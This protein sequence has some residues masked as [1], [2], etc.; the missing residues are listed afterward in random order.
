MENSQLCTDINIYTQDDIDANAKIIEL[1]IDKSIE[2]VK[3]MPLDELRRY[4]R[5]ALQINLENGISDVLYITNKKNLS[6]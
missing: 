4:K 2:F 6:S 1:Y 3:N 5:I